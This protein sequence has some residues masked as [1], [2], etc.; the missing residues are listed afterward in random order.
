MAR[1]F[2]SVRYMMWNKVRFRLELKIL[3]PSNNP[4]II[5]DRFALSCIFFLIRK[6]K[7]CSIDSLLKHLIS[8]NVGCG[9]GTMGCLY[10]GEIKRRFLTW[11]TVCSLCPPFVKVG[12]YYACTSHS[13]F[14]HP[15]D[16]F[17]I[18]LDQ[19]CSSTGQCTRHLTQN[20]NRL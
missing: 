6:V 16:P 11:Y 17:I 5:K 2:C 20:L 13:V 4:L 8:C 3:H 10:Q 18:V 19:Y 9:P 14:P 1:I 15:F 12:P 7:T